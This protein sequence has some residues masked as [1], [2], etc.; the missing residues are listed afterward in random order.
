MNNK[1]NEFI[2][3]LGYQYLIDS[4]D[5][6]M[7]TAWVKKLDRTPEQKRIITRNIKIVGKRKDGTIQ[8]ILEDTL[9]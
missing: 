8:A 2:I 9:K 1:W 6:K 5:K 4:M 7:L 3:R